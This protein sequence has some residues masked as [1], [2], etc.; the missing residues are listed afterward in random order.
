MTKREGA[1]ISAF[2]GILCSNFE[3]LHKYVEEIM[4]RPIFTHEMGDKEIAKEI[5]AKSKRDFIK[6]IEN[7]N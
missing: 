7:Q 5:K 3:E 2:T 1:I 4:E 6:L